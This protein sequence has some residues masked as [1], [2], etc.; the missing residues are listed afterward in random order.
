MRYVYNP[1][2]PSGKRIVSA[3][4][5][6]ANGAARAIEPATRYRVAMV[7]YLE[8][9]GDG[10]A[11]LANGAPVETPDAADVEVLAAYIKKHSPLTDLPPDRLTRQ[12]R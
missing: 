2:L 11:M 1:E 12:T 4:L 8:R 5:L 6:E 3:E 7:D 9:K 10:Y